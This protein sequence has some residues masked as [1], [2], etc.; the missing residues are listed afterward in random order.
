[1]IDLRPVYYCDLEQ[2]IRAHIILFWLSG[3][4]DPKFMFRNVLLSAT[5]EYESNW[6]FELCLTWSN[7]LRRVQ[8]PGFSLGKCSLD[9]QLSP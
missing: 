1:M 2:H 5:K 8:H 3:P 9:V 7:A 4:S 6:I